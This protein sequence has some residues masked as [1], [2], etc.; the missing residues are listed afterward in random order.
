MTEHASSVSLDR[1]A[2]LTQTVTT[3]VCRA[4]A[5]FAWQNLET[6]WRYQPF[7]DA[8]KGLL[9]SMLVLKQQQDR[10]LSMALEQWQV[11]SKPEFERVLHRLNEIEGRLQDLQAKVDTIARH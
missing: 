10:A 11:P 4:W 2:Q 8:N 7:V 1:I 5:Q 6:L 9:N 3:E